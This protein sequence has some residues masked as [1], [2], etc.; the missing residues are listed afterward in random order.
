MLR[1]RASAKGVGASDGFEKM[2]AK[3]VKGKESARSYWHSNSNITVGL[4]LSGQ[5]LPVPDM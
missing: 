5:E 4:M 3:E 1:G 2:L